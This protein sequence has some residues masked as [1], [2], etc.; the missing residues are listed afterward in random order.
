MASI[1][2]IGLLNLYSA[3]H[4]H[5]VAHMANLYKMQLGWFCG[6]LVIA[7][8]ASFI[9]PKNLL[10]LSYPIYFLN[11]ILLVLVL[12]LGDEAMGGKRWLVLG[13]LRLQPSEPMKISL[14]LALS[15][16]FSKVE[17]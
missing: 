10:K 9:G 16:W 8:V 2:F 3:T 12:I 7:F 1:F 14:V 4:A 13:P 15:R 5:T 17:G 6:C 11:V